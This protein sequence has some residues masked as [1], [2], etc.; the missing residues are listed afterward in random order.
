MSERA[1]QSADGSAAIVGRSRQEQPAGE[2]ASEQRANDAPPRRKAR[3]LTLLR[4]ITIPVTAVV[5]AI[6]PAASAGTADSSQ[7]AARQMPARPG[8]SI[9]GEQSCGGV[10]SPGRTAIDGTCG[11][12]LR[13]SKRS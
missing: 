11:L 10:R 3:R 8:V 13:V 4:A 2:P 12:R 5:P 6:V 7:K 9:G 1:D